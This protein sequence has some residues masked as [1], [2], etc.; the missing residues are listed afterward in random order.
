MEKTSKLIPHFSWMQQIIKHFKIQ[1]QTVKFVTTFIWRLSRAKDH[2]IE[3]PHIVLRRGRTNSRRCVIRSSHKTQT[4]NSVQQNTTR[5]E[6]PH[7]SPRQHSR[8][9]TNFTK[10]KRRHEKHYPF[11]L[12]WASKALNNCWKFQLTWLTEQTLRFLLRSN[13]AESPKYS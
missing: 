6:F 5:M 9:L 10:K 2:H 8:Y 4:I 12:A 1:N 3:I 11:N 7:K 13:I